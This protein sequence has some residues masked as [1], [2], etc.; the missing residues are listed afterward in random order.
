[1][2]QP[3]SGRFSQIDREELDNEQI[4]V[5]SSR[6]TCEVTILQPHARV[7][8]AVV[9]GDVAQHSK[10]S[11]EMSVAHGASKHLWSRPFMT[12]ATSFTIIVAHSDAGLVRVAGTASH[13]PLGDVIGTSEVL[14]RHSI[15]LGGR[16]SKSLPVRKSFLHPQLLG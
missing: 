5:R 15:G 16:R 1:M 4:I 3:G 12:E 11:W 6:S 9:F 14:T 7:G 2:V 13:H 8:F 10:A